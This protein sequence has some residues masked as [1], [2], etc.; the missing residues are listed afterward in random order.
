MSDIGIENFLNPLMS[1]GFLMFILILG[2][3]GYVKV[4]KPIFSFITW[5]FSIIFGMESMKIPYLPFTP[6]LQIFIIL[7]QTYFFMK[8]AIA[9]KLFKKR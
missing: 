2:V 4:R 8:L 5:M 1:L 3:Y 9:G 7:F 6:F